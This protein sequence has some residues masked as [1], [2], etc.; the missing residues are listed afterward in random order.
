MIDN[1]V[2]NNHIP[3]MYE[4]T[5]RR[6]KGIPP[7]RYDSEFEAQ[8]SK[9]PVSKENNE[10]LSQTAR[11]FNV[12]L[13]SNSVPKNVEEA[14]RDP[15]SKKAMEEEISALDKNETWEKM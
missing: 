11:A 5:P 14:L 6:T 4:L 13:Y 1:Y 15:R 8:R 3:S 7:K 10:V 12:A 2:V 9:Y